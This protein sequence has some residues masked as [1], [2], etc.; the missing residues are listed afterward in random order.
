MWGEA[1][2]AEGL[3]DCPN[4]RGHWNTQRRKKEARR[5]VDIYL[6]PSGEAAASKQINKLH[7]EVNNIGPQ[8]QYCL[9]IIGAQHQ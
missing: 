5:A 8:A 2:Q 6:L 9:T 4:N 1:P 3:S 7:E